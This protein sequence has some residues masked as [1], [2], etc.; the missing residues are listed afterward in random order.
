MKSIL[1]TLD[2]SGKIVHWETLNNWDD[3]GTYY[4]NS[5]DF[6]KETLLN[7]VETENVVPIVFP[8]DYQKLYSEFEKS[9]PGYFNIIE[10]D[11]VHDYKEYVGLMERYF[12]C[13]KCDE[14]KDE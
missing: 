12:Y 11:C 6:I 14:K 4:F 3:Q 5:Q 7:H 1:Y 10:E 9:L 2:D 8:K 13:V